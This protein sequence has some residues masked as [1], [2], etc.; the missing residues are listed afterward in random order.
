M[1]TARQLFKLTHFFEFSFIQYQS[2][3]SI[4]GTILPASFVTQS[5]HDCWSRRHLAWKQTGWW[6][7]VLFNLNYSKT[8]LFIVS[9]VS[10]VI[11]NSQ[12]YFGAI[13]AVSCGVS[14]RSVLVVKVVFVIEYIAVKKW[15]RFFFSKDVCFRF[16][17][18]ISPT[19]DPITM[20]LASIF[21]SCLSPPD[22]E[23]FK[24]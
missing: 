13:K 23:L 9:P 21:K 17:V 2:Y 18:P 8:I 10:R 12:Q 19:F 22:N 11:F 14:K 6:S 1:N 20:I 3:P 16:S 5:F 15:L 24:I 7:I 4:I